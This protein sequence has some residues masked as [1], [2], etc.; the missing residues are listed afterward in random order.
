MSSSNNQT[1]LLVLWFPPRIWNLVTNF[2]RPRT[3]YNPISTLEVQSLFV[4]RSRSLKMTHSLKGSVTYW[5]V[6]PNWRS[7]WPSSSRVMERLNMIT[8]M[9]SHSKRTKRRMMRSSSCLSSPKRFMILQWTRTRSICK[10]I[11]SKRKGMAGS[12]LTQPS[13]MWVGPLALTMLSPTIWV[14]MSTYQEK[15]IRWK[16]HSWE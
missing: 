5:V 6:R 7:V 2:L 1:S 8:N 9:A 15:R 11:Y 14:R 16:S 12:S 10:L 4:P 3:N 13:R